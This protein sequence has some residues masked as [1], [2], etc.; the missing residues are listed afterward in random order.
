MQQSVVV[1][2]KL[3]VMCQRNSGG[4]AK[5]QA[6]PFSA[7]F[8]S[9]TKSVFAHGFPIAVSLAPAASA[10]TGSGTIGHVSSQVIP[11]GV[12]PFW[13]LAVL[14][15]TDNS[16][17][18]VLNSIFSDSYARAFMIKGRDST[19]QNCTFRRAGGLHVGPE[20]GWL[21]GD[22]GIKNVTVEDN[23]FVSSLGSSDL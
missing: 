6:A 5:M 22:P 14:E 9:H 23:L 21:E 4:F 2:N 17:A 16:G 11:G 15:S 12:S 10:R 13:S 19:F 1:S 3:I 7:H 8:V 20:Q 18:R